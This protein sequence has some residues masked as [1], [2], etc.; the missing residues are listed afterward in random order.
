MTVFVTA[1]TEIFV[2]AQRATLRDLGAGMGV[3]IT[4]EDPTHAPRV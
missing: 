1:F 3:S 2:N 4:L